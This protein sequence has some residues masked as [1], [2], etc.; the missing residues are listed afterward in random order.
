MTWAA[1]LVPRAR[2]PLI[3]FRVGRRR[4]IEHALRHRLDYLR[5]VRNLEKALR[6]CEVLVEHALAD[7]VEHSL[8]LLVRLALD[9]HVRDGHFCGQLFAQRKLE[10]QTLAVQL[11]LLLLVLHVIIARQ[12]AEIERRLRRIV[13]CHIGRADAVLCRYVRTAKLSVRAAQGGARR[14]ELLLLMDK[15]ISLR[16]HQFQV[17]IILLWMQLLL[18]TLQLLICAFRYHF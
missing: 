13:V 7:G 11:S 2:Q 6:H 16:R 10:A 18:C 12:V 8:S 3:L 4:P 9:Q 15:F 14:Q 17:T 1:A 5:A